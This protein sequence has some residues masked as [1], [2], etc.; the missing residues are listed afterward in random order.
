MPRLEVAVEY[1]GGERELVLASRPANL[2][3]FA[4]HFDKVAPESIG[5]LVWLTW[6]ALGEPG[7][8]LEAWV[9]T[10]LDI[11]ASDEVVGQVREAVG[12]AQ[13]GELGGTVTELP[14]EPAAAEQVP[15]PSA[16]GGAPAEPASSH[17]AS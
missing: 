6:R 16:E 3:A 14:R 7:G 9:E 1:E 5:E 15:T 12:K 13:A 11:D 8:S 2:I 17:G 10:L 4:D